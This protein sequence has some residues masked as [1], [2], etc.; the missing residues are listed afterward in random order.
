MSIPMETITETNSPLTAGFSWRESNG[1]LVLTCDT[2]SAEGFVNGFS[3]RLGGVSPMPEADLNLAG[4]ADDDAANIYENRRRFL[5]AFEGQW[6]LT[7]CWQVHGNDVRVVRDADDARNDEDRCDALTGSV[8]GILLGVKTAD[9]VPVLLGDP[10]TGAVAAVH[11]GWRGTLATIVPETIGRMVQEFGT[12]PEDLRVAIGPAAASCCYEVGHEVVDL[13]NQK[14][15][16]A[17]DLFQPTHAGHA[18]IDLQGANRQQFIA[19][20]VDPARIQIANLC[21]ICR[22]DLFF[23]YRKEKRT[24]G[25]TGRLM[26]VIGTTKR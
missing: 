19:A 17:G 18:V 1:V 21:T 6:T 9:C 11:A 10:R 23:S 16:Y 20:G 15:E 26:S 24:Q 22:T 14:F 7:S 25:K 8:P 13:F 5:S 3:T 12:R 4:F 2:L